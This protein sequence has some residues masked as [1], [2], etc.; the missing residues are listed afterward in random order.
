MCVDVCRGVS[1]RD[2]SWVYTELHGRRRHRKKRRLWSSLALTISARIRPVWRHAE[3]GCCTTVEG[4]P[5]LCPILEHQ[6]P[7]LFT[8]MCPLTASLG[9][10]RWNQKAVDTCGNAIGSCAS[11]CARVGQL[12]VRLDRSRIHVRCEG[13]ACSPSEDTR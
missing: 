9:N 7:D 6:S 8:S 5:R 11:T 4:S 13:H 3:P 10:L 1:H 2:V 12:D